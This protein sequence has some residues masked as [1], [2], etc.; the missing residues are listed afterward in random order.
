MNRFDVARRAAIA[1]ALGA[2][3][4]L[5]AG[6]EPLSGGELKREIES[7][8]SA[9]AEGAVLAQQVASQDTKRTFAR[10]HARELADAT[11]HSAEHLTDA[12]PEE[13]IRD[14]A[15]RAIGLAEDV[16]SQIGEIEVAPDDAVAAAEVA[17]RLRELSDQASALADS[18]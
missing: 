10:V 11:E 15:E 13:E 3:T 7:V 18:L 14:E 9:A 6:C 2:V 5:L 1:V 4:A 16:S 17:S 8:G 12:H